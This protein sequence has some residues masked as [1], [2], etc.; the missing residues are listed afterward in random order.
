MDVCYGKDY[1]HLNEGN[2]PVLGTGGVMGYVDEY[3]YSGESILIGRK[4]TIDK[5]KYIIFPYS[6]K[7]NF[8]ASVTGDTIPAFLYKFF[9]RSISQAYK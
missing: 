2:F 4:G 5:P 9:L 1:K 3:L 8:Y 6:H 7:I